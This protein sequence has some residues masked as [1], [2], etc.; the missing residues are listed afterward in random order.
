MHNDIFLDEFETYPLGGCPGLH[1]SHGAEDVLVPHHQ[2]L[3]LEI[4]I[5]VHGARRQ[6][7]VPDFTSLSSFETHLL[8]LP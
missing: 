3:T 6:T 5:T 1:F 8:L 4:A 2:C 7:P